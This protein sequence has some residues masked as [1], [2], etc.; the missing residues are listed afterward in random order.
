MAPK[1][2]S[3]FVIPAITQAV[4]R[5]LVAD[6]VV[7]ALE[8]QATT[9]GNADNTNRNSKPREALIE[10]K[11]S[12]IE[13]ISCQLVN[14]KGTEGAVRLIRWFECTELVLFCS[15]YTE[16]YKVNFAIGTLTEETLS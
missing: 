16:D 2:T 7:T 4:I 15:N 14:F 5:K 11:C 1:R 6:S 10:R 12:Y 3:T 8:A 9:M 13:F